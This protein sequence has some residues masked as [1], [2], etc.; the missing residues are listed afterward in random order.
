MKNYNRVS[1]AADANEAQQMVFKLIKEGF[2]REHI[3]VLTH[4]EGEANSG[5]LDSEPFLAYASSFRACGDEL[6]GKIQAIGIELP[7]A[8][9][10][11]SEL[12]QGKIAVI[13]FTMQR[14]SHSR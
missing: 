11:E 2:I 3:F 9:L 5:L 12:I 10:L 4:E 1:I 6:R 14:E 7:E 13:A 8:A